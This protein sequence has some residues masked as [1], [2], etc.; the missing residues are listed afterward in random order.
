MYYVHAPNGAKRESKMATKYF[1][2]VIWPAI[3]WLDEDDRSHYVGID[4][5]EVR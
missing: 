2:R 1:E 5:K 4:S 3:G